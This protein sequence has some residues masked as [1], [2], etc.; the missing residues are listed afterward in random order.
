MKKVLSVIALSVAFS[1]MFSEQVFASEPC[2]DK[3]CEHVY[4]GPQKGDF[5]LSFNAVPI[6]NF[7]GNMFN[8]TVGQSI[9]GLTSLTNPL[10]SGSAISG[11]YYLTDRFGVTAG[12]GLN[13]TTSRSYEYDDKYEDKEE[14]TKTGNRATMLTLGAQY[15]LCPGKRLQPVLGANLIYAYSSKSF[16]DVDDLENDKNDYYS[17]SPSN[18]FGIVAN[19]GVE[20]YLSKAISL[21]AYLDLG[22]TTT[23][24]RTKYSTE[25]KEYSYVSSKRTQFM[26]GRM[27]GNFAINFYF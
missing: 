16:T 26:T 17:K 19:L 6:V 8:G 2:K 1:A 18:S 11:S 21:A 3:N 10:F 5:A 13:N 7:I 22:L 27:G 25:E 23:T 4:Y 15:L 12:I 20:Y 14:I 9:D 24:T